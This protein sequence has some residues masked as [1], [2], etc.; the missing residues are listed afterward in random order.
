MLLYNQYFYDIK[1]L[2]CFDVIEQYF[3]FIEQYFDFIEQ[4]FDFIVF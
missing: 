2:L 1:K 4:Y 3:D